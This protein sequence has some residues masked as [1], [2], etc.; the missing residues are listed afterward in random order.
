P[1]EKFG[2]LKLEIEI[3][4]YLRLVMGPKA[5]NGIAA[6]WTWISVRT[7]DKI[8]NVYPNNNLI[9]RNEIALQSIECN[10]IYILTDLE[11]SAC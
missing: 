2:N 10:D 5:N 8:P 1:S 6:Y 7:F 11:F 9:I 4:E 3:R